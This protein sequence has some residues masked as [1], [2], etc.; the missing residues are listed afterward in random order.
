[1]LKSLKVLDIS[2]NEI[3][4]HSVDT[5]RYLCSFPMTHA[6]KNDWNFEE[7]ANVGVD[8]TNHW[9]AFFIFRGLNLIQL[10]ILGNAV[11]SDQLKQLLFKLMPS[12]NW[13]DGENR[14]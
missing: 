6:V 3:G 5:R 12:L 10:D 2:Y 8:L 4:A 7:F 9:D 1:M 11:V 13:F 14:N